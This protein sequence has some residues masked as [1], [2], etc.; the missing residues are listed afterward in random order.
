MPSLSNNAS[1]NLSPQSQL[2]DKVAQLIT[3]PTYENEAPGKTGANQ[4]PI[5][6]TEVKIQ[7]NGFAGNTPPTDSRI[8]IWSS[9]G[10]SPAYSPDISLTTTADGSIPPFQTGSLEKQARGGVQF[11]IGFTSP[12]GAFLTWGVD[13]SLDDPFIARIREDNT[14]STGDFSD[15]DVAISSSSSLNG[16]LSYEI[17]YETAP[18]AVQNL[19]VSGGA[20]NVSLSWDAPL[21]NGGGTITG[22]KIQRSTDGVSFSNLEANTESTSTSFTDTDASPGN[23]FTYRVSAHN[24]ATAIFD[25]SFTG[26]FSEEE[27]ITIAG[28][29]GNTTSELEISVSRAEPEILQF[30]DFGAGIPFTDLDLVLGS[31][32]LYNRIVV[33]PAEGST[34]TATAEESRDEYG[35]RVFS[36]S[37][38]NIDDG[39]AL[40]VAN[41]LLYRFFQPDVRVASI[42]INMQNLTPSQR[43]E[44]LELE[45]D[46]GARV[47]FQPRKPGGQVVGDPITTTSRIISIEHNITPAEHIVRLGF[48]REATVIFTLDSVVNGLLDQNLLG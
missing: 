41:E 29:P 3:L 8:G 17:Q 38:L 1:P 23:T 4:Y 30:A 19:T 22:Y 26:P 39:G 40:A 14:S 20:G 37:T 35:L 44:I 45:L 18:S 10:T 36:I 9:D 15:D 34:A 5:R 12:P 16:Q 42:S 32:N 24:T 46:A 27:S 28:V 7:Y 13:N 21:D 48:D 31:E 11:W 25:D 6:V 43:L 2:N 47:S 33:T